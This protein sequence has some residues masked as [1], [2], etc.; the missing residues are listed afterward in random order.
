MYGYSLVELNPL[1]LNSSHIFGLAEEK[2]RCFGTL[3]AE[4]LIVSTFLT[5][6]SYLAMPIFNGGLEASMTNIFLPM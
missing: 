6:F 3:L 4:K 2:I 5:G 1:L